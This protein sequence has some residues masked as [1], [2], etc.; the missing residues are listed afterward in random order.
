MT[1]QTFSKQSE[2]LHEWG[3]SHNP[4]TAVCFCS[5]SDPKRRGLHSLDSP[6][7]TR[8]LLLPTTSLP[9]DKSPTLVPQTLPQ[10]QQEL[11]LYP[12][13]HVPNL[14]ALKI[15]PSYKN[16]TLNS[17]GSACSFIFPH[18]YHRISLIES[19][20][21]QLKLLQRN[22]RSPENLQ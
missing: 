11:Q 8:D 10:E 21:E 12:H 1:D 9:R 16:T 15:T 18:H 3:T 7:E 22:S 6:G 4:E 5:K 2:V 17:Q 20:A 14:Y 19:E 13:L